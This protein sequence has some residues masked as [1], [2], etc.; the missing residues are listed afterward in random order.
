MDHQEQHHNEGAMTFAKHMNRTSYFG[1]RVWVLALWT[2]PLGFLFGPVGQPWGL[3]MSAT[4]GICMGYL[5]T[6]EA[7]RRER[8]A[9]DEARRSYFLD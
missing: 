6:K 1:A 9:A 3:L 2:A 7:D 8:K 4:V 5:I